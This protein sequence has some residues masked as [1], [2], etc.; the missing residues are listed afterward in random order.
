[1]PYQ[2]KPHSH[3]KIW[4]TNNRD[5]F[6]IFENQTRLIAMREQNPKDPIHLI[7][8]S[9]L[10]SEQA[11]AELM[12][13]CKENTITP[14]DADGFKDQLQSEDER[15]L[16]DLY[17]DEISHLKEGGN[18]GVASDIL[19]W[20]SPSYRLGSYTDLD[21]PLN[22]GALP[23]E[24][25]V[26]APLLLN[27]GSLKLLGTKEMV[28]T[29][30]EYIA[31][32]DEEKAKK[33]IEQIHRG[34]IRKLQHYSSD[35]IQ[36]TEQMLSQGSFLNRILMGYMKNRAEALY[37]QKSTELEPAN[38]IHTSRN[39]RAYV[40]EIMKDTNK[41]LDFKKQSADE[42][43][44][45]VIQRLRKE[46]ASQQTFSKWLFFRKEYYEAR[47]ALGQADE[48]FVKYLM[49]KERSLYLKSIVI[50]T[51]GPIEVAN[52]LYGTYVMKSREINKKVKPMTFSHYNLD[53]AF[54][55]NNVVPLHENPLSM[56]KFLG[57]DVGELNDSSWLEE[58]M[59][60]QETRQ[61]KLLA[62]QA[63][64]QEELPDTLKNMKTK[65]EAHIQKLKNES[66][67][68]F[69]FLWVSRREAKIAALTSVLQCFDAN[70][71]FDIRQF[72][73]ILANMDKK[74]VFSGFF[75][76]ITEQLIG[77][78]NEICHEAI[79]LRAA[80]DKKL[81]GIAEAKKLAV[82]SPTVTEELDGYNP[83]MSYSCSRS[84]SNRF[85]GQPAGKAS[86]ASDA[87]EMDVRYTCGV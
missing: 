5:V 33:Q 60:L 83:S 61:Q 15:T 34:L 42:T 10:L 74:T 77:Q 81:S 17:K 49:Q 32:V 54:L 69:S 64:L 58:G 22:T 11:L 38:G 19:R 9:S 65:I 75:T 72:R 3:V 6:M 13:F 16:F 28:L 70:N 66:K 78:L 67:S 76:R 12:E 73:S 7:Y 62:R 25:T 48:K 35:Y 29:L 84:Y 26:D 4:L 55:S 2:Y 41:Y 46:L 71:T 36:K 37:I 31:V 68:W 44:E 56:L 1:M 21:V 30:N 53:A 40:N 51:T 45:E 86:E 20:L 8:D 57:A 85:F 18:L 80:K 59:A 82:V 47:F 27:I 43:K 87:E 23:E 50:C 79:V 63:A 24:V 52:S 39:L 14:V